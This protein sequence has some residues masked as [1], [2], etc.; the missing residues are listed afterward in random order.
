MPDNGKAD[1]NFPPGILILWR[2]TVGRRGA[3]EA[4]T[5]FC[6]VEPCVDGMKLS[7]GAAEIDPVC[8][9]SPTDRY[10]SQGMAGLKKNTLLDMVHSMVHF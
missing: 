6:D 2:A 10:R 1:M 5:P 9:R 4:D 7:A 3:K 8:W